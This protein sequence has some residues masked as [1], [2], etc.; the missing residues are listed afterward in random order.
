MTRHVITKSTKTITYGSHPDVV[1]AIAVWE[2]LVFK[3]Q[4]QCQK[5]NYLN[6]HTL[7]GLTTEEVGQD[8]II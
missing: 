4:L 7:Y 2:I 3:Y 8:V 1:P 6:T 5:Q